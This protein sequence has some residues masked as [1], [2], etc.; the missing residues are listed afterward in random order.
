MAVIASL[1]GQNT[2][3]LRA[4]LTSA[5]AVTLQ[6]SPARVSPDPRR[7]RGWRIAGRV[8]V[9][10]GHC[11]TLKSGSENTRPGAQR[12][13]GGRRFPGD[14]RRKRGQKEVTLAAAVTA[15]RSTDRDPPRRPSDAALE[16]TL[17]TTWGQGSE[18]WSNPAG[19]S[20]VGL[21]F[22]VLVARHSSDESTT[23]AQVIEFR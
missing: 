17:R 8:L 1:R 5:P 16:C 18:S 14:I 21:A 7:I 4:R 11:R 3:A 9:P 10:G 12:G 19:L 6:R 15:A 13:P 20:F 22:R 23:K 2:L